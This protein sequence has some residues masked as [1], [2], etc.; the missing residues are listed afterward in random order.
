MRCAVPVPIPL[1][2]TDTL[3]KLLSHLTLGR[4]V[5]RITLKS[6][7]LKR[8]RVETCL[9][10]LF[11][12]ILLRV[13][14]DAGCELVTSSMPFLCQPRK[15]QRESRRAPYLRVVDC[16]GIVDCLR[17]VFLRVGHYPFRWHLLSINTRYAPGFVEHLAG[18]L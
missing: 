15:D 3:R 9:L 16:F 12:Q 18:F 10:L 11:G 17:D 6:D 8:G 13:L 2:D 5:A 7:Q 14:T 4:A 1:Q